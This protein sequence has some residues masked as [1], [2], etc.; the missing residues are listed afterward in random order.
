MKKKLLAVLLAL[1]LCLTVPLSA[2]AA[3]LPGADRLTAAAKRLT[4]RIAGDLSAVEVTADTGAAF[5]DLLLNAYNDAGATAAELPAVTPAAQ[6]R[7]PQIRRHTDD[8]PL[9]PAGKYTVAELETL[10]RKYL[11]IKVDDPAAAAA[12]IADT[13]E[14]SYHL[15]NGSDGTL[16]LRVDVE[17]NPEIFNYDVFRSL[18]EQL[19]EKQGEEMQKDSYGKIDYVMSYEHIAG[20]L[21]LHAIVFAVI[22]HI[23]SLSDSRDERLVKLYNEAAQADLNPDESRIPAGI[24]RLLGFLIIHVFQ[25]NVLKVFSF[26]A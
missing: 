22:N 2:G 1:A 13:C 4:D 15:V 3:T 8:G 7:A 20:E 26:L 12:L 16:Y 17:N 14:F 21:A 10:I 5:T 25:Y 19:Y 18:V 24:I 6:S 11:F 23:F 9:T